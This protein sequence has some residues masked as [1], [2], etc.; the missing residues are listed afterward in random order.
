MAKKISKA[1]K[2][3]RIAAAAATRRKNEEKRK[4]DELT[5]W[6]QEFVA[7]NLSKSEKEL[8]INHLRLKLANTKAKLAD[9]REELASLKV[10]NETWSAESQAVYVLTWHEDDIT[11]LATFVERLKEHEETFDWCR[12]PGL[13]RAGNN[14]LRIWIEDFCL[15]LGDSPLLPGYVADGYKIIKEMAD[16]KPLSH[17]F[18]ADVVVK[19]AKG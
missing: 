4:R 7:D 10:S 5:K 2:E 3:R 13:D 17:A 19:M 9:T 12:F 16:Y 14:L 18:L 8:K 15:G 6:Q 1:E 11:D